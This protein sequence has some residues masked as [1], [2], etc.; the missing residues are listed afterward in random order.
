VEWVV[1]WDYGLPSKVPV[2]TNI[3]TPTG[4]KSTA[5]IRMTGQK[6]PRPE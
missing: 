5:P 1:S 6:H 4:F 2:N 3:S